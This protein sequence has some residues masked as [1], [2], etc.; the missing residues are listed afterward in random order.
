MPNFN[1]HFLFY[2]GVKINGACY[3]D[4]QLSR[5]LLP[6]IRSL[7]PEGCFVFQQDNVPAHRAQETIEMLTRETPDLISLAL[8]PPNSSDLNPVEWTIKCGALCKSE[9]TREESMM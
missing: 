5:H 9:S 7:A 4:V 1:Y 6:V 2:P 3:Q 8:W